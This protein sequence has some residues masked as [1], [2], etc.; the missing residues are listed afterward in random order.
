MVSGA[1]DYPGIGQAATGDGAD[2]ATEAE[3]LRGQGVHCRRLAGSISDART[4]RTLKDMAQD[5]ENQAAQL[6]A[7]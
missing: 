6:T 4:V 2:K 7:R 1:E 5:Y 3:Y